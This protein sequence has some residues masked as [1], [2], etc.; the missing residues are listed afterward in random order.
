MSNSTT[1]CGNAQS[2]KHRKPSVTPDD[3]FHRPN[4]QPILNRSVEGWTQVGGIIH[5]VL[6][7]A[8]HETPLHKRAEAIEALAERGIFLTAGNAHTSLAGARA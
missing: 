2:P 1:I 5:Q 7:G 4:S 6:W 3:R 8:V